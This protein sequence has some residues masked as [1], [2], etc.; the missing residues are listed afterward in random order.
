MEQ[1]RVSTYK[2]ASLKRRISP[3]HLQL[4]NMKKNNFS[5][6][7]TLLKL[8]TEEAWSHPGHQEMKARWVLTECED[9]WSH[10]RSPVGGVLLQQVQAEA[11]DL[12]LDAHHDVGVVLIPLELVAQAHHAV[13]DELV[14]SRQVCLDSLKH[15]NS[16]H[17][18]FNHLWAPAGTQIKVFL[19]C[20]LTHW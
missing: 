11:G 3:S 8:L 17:H 19:C 12:L 1:P 7:Q 16:R 2:K 10:Q 14:L 20:S 18:L 15:H 13:P 9:I 4:S 6:I 5:C